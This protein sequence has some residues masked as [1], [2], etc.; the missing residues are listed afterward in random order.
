MGKFNVGNVA[1]GF[2][3]GAIATIILQTVTIGGLGAIIK[4]KGGA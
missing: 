3:I 4:A 2:A 1:K